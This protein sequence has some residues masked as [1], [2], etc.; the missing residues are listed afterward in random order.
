ML[1]PNPIEF[2]QYLVMAL[3]RLRYTY[4]QSLMIF[5]Q[6]YLVILCLFM[7]SG[8]LVNP[9]AHRLA[10]LASHHSSVIL[11]IIDDLVRTFS[12]LT[13]LAWGRI[14]DPWLVRFVLFSFFFGKW[15]TILHIPIPNPH[16]LEGRE[17][18]QSGASL[19]NKVVPFHRAYYFARDGQRDRKR[20]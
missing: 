16:L 20:G 1:I 9:C 19:P 8:S 5:T 4:F 13:F 7:K 17:Q 3:K 14:V 12:S 2:Y 18:G 15:Y 6:L 10:R 11:E